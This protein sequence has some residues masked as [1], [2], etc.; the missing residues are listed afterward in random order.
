MIE[1]N[2][3]SA[4][5]NLPSHAGRKRAVDFANNQNSLASLNGI[6]LCEQAVASNWHAKFLQHKEIIGTGLFENNNKTTQLL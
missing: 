6:E 1:S 2:G 5:S 4:S 3:M